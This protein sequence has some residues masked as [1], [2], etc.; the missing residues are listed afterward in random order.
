MN[1]TVLTNS[2]T[3]T[4]EVG[5]ALAKEMK[6]NGIY[7][8]IRLYGEMGVGKTAFTRGFCRALGISGVKSPTYTMVN[9]YLGSD[10]VYHFDMVRISSEDDLY[11]IGFDDYIATPKAFL[12]FEWTENIDEYLGDGGV[13]ITIS[14][15]AEDENKREIT[16]KVGDGYTV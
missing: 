10:T 14:R 2:P 13:F 11:S 12:L 5:F 16:I 4:E 3:E 8:H 6:E 15:V 7:A 1:K 9:E